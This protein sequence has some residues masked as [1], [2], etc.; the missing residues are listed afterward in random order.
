MHAQ[1]RLL[2]LLCRDR[3]PALTTDARAILVMALYYA[4][5][6]R[7]ALVQYASRPLSD[8][9]PLL[10]LYARA[11]AAVMMSTHGPALTRLKDSI[12]TSGLCDLYTLVYE[13]VCAALPALRGQLLQHFAVEAAELRRMRQKAA[14]ATRAAAPSQSREDLRRQRLHNGASGVLVISDL[15]DTLV[16]GWLE[17]RYV[18]GAPVPGALDLVHELRRASQAEDAA[19]AMWQRPLPPNWF[20]DVLRVSGPSPAPSSPDVA[21]VTSES[22]IAASG[23]GHPQQQTQ[24][25]IDDVDHAE[26]SF[27]ALALGRYYSAVPAQAASRWWRRWRQRGAVVGGLAASARDAFRR[28]RLTVQDNHPSSLS[29]SSGEGGLSANVPPVVWKPTTAQQQVP[30][31]YVPSDGY[32]SAPVPSPSSSATGGAGESGLAGLRALPVPAALLAR[33]R[34]PCAAAAPRNSAGEVL[35]AAAFMWPALA[36]DASPT[37]AGGGLV[38]DGVVPSSVYIVTARP[39]DLR[40]TLK[41]RTL[42]SLRFLPFRCHL[43][44]LLGSVLHSASTSAIVGKKLDNALAAAALWPEMNLVLLGDSGQGDTAV[45]LHAVR[46]LARTRGRRRGSSFV[47]EA[48]EDRIEP[49]VTAFIHHVCPAR[50]GGG[51]AASAAASGAAVESMPT[52]TGCGTAIGPADRLALAEAGVHVCATWGHAAVAAAAEGLLTTAS[53]QAVAVGALREMTAQFGRGLQAAEDGVSEADN[54]SAPAAA[55][56]AA[57]SSSQRAVAAS[58]LQLHAALGCRDGAAEAAWLAGA[59]STGLHVAV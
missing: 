55:R 48:A 28:A 31:Y 14:A 16:C 10:P 47:E 7:R 56:V 54:A 4:G 34:H 49:T 23:P 9:A 43:V 53:A 38:H 8:P 44:A 32:A 42:E 13:D 15:D 24:V 18:R 5:R 21:A 26:P 57:L 30:L 52:V 39:A 12:N 59:V 27:M 11:I 19:A 58:I 33:L 22:T 50:G 29:E 20:A 41:R 1:Q 35:V 46:T 3:L 17:S 40:G 25:R 37:A 51:R 2:D 36:L 6:G 45:C